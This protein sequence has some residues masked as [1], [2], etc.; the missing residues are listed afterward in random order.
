[1]L[2]IFRDSSNVS[3]LSRCL[4]F[5][6]FCFFSKR[7]V[8]AAAAFSL[9]LGDPRHLT[10]SSGRR[11]R[12]GPRFRDARYGESLR[13]CSDFESR[14]KMEQGSASGGRARCGGRHAQRR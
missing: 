13:W 12:G 11:R 7:A 2:R 14:G 9:L 6:I 10:R 8:A 4:V 5:L 1:M 3:E